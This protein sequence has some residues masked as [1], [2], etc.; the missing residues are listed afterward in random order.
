SCL[1]LHFSGEFGTAAGGAPG[2]FGNYELDNNGL[3]ALA[4]LS[5]VPAAGGALTIELKNVQGQAIVGPVLLR[6]AAVPLLAP[7]PC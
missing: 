7:N 2:F 6:R 5:A 3:D 4:A 1:K